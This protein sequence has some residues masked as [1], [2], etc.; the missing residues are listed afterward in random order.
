MDDI[1]DK[2]VDLILQQLEDLPTLPAVATRLLELTSNDESRLSEIVQLIESD[3]SLST[4]ILQLVNR[5]GSGVR[6]E[7]SSVERAV[8][9]LGFD[10]VRSAVLALSVFDTFKSVE[11]RVPTSFDREA[12]WK[13]SLA[14]ACL[15]ELLASHMPRT[16][17]IDP[18]EAF[19]CGLLHDIGK[20]AFDAALP[21]SF[22]RVVETADMLRGDLANIE[23]SIIGL[24]HMVAGK[25]LAERWNLPGTLRESIWLHGQTPH[26]LPATVR[27]ARLINLVTLA[28]ALAR[29]HH[30]GYSGNYHFDIPRAELLSASGVTTTQIDEALSVLMDRLQQRSATLGL[31]REAVDALYRDALARANKELLNANSQLTTRNRKLAVRAKFFETLAAFQG[32]LRPDAPPQHVL[33]AIAHTAVSALA[34]D[35]CAA[36]SLSS[37]R[38]FAES[39]IVNAQ[40]ELTD[41][42]LI[43]LPRG[44]CPGGAVQAPANG[45]VRAADD[46][47]DW[48]LNAISPRLSHSQRYWI[49]LEADGVAIGGVVWGAAVGEAQRLA[50]QVQELTALSAGWSL[51]LRTAQIREEAR[52]LSEQLAESN[53]QLQAAQNEI[54]RS[55][56]L[57]SLGEMAGGAAHEMNNPLA[58]ISGRSQLLSQELQD[59]RQK[60][61]AH[62]VYEQSQRLSDIITDL[63]D[64][65]RPS[66]ARPVETDAVELIHKAI[67]E[68][69]M[70]NEHADRKFE[71]TAGDLPPVCVDPAQ[72]GA[73]IS[74]VI[75]NAI[76]ATD[77]HGQIEIH[78][79]YDSYSQQVVISVTDNGR[80]MDEETLKRAF[81]PFYSA[82]R[83]G[84]R[85][86]LGLAK[87]LRWA[88][89]SGGTIRIE[90]HPGQGTRALVLLPAVKSEA[91]EIHPQLRKQA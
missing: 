40:G 52:T 20:I 32:E 69:K 19:V 9:L 2:R 76:Q 61:S 68:A 57:V 41:T 58:V 47:L 24:D 60:A 48:L 83:A 73:A 79:G 74:E 77:E 10:A 22:S 30:L 67:H 63:M 75:G 59:P 34:V 87:A 65:A 91:G 55:R 27:N 8:V 37:T 3:P 88:E 11:P 49:M 82:K 54:L 84:R 53:R 31:G 33:R 1:R 44:F 16:S 12:F 21:K 5:A 45:P 7:I 66:P 23:R 36:W 50:A 90:S 25:R 6:G 81:D 35:V 26:A 4:R 15:A 17:G 51:A 28:D 14:T 18:A 29:E 43:N 56:T 70:L 78:S 85:R 62:L 13:H 72:V 71:L 39:V 64:F 38:Q 89:G 80:G 86:G 42:S 46:S